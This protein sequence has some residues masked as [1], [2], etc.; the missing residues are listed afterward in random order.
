MRGHED[1]W[2]NS[3]CSST[4][5][6]S[7]SQTRDVR[8]RGIPPFSGGLREETLEQSPLWHLAIAPHSP[9]QVD[10]THFGSEAV[11]VPAVQ[12]DERVGKELC[13]REDMEKV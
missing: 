11:T 12:C 9:C 2:S 13:V 7:E 5:T 10:N 1:S 3:T 8:G 4:P 6:T